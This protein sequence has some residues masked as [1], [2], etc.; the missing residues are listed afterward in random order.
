MSIFLFS[1]TGGKDTIL[2]SD[3]AL[4]TMQRSRSPLLKFVEQP[5]ENKASPKDGKQALNFLTLSW[6]V[7]GAGDEWTPVLHV[8][9]ASAALLGHPSC[10]L[11]FGVSSRRTLVPALSAQWNE[12]KSEGAGFKQ[13]GFILQP[14]ITLVVRT[15]TGNFSFSFLSYKTM[16]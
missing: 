1:V 9:A 7:P 11:L 8:S 5:S 16:R 15:W 10:F 2:F 6:P 12:A 3:P 14:H 13:P 4:P